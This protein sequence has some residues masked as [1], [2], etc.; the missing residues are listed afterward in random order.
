MKL[1]EF[2]S[3]S[4]KERKD[5]MAEKMWELAYY[6]FDLVE[7]SDS[8]LEERERY[9]RLISVGINAKIEDI[10]ALYEVSLK[11]DPRPEEG[12]K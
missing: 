8:G 6:V 12:Y 1:C 5:H 10:M 7:S 11:C 3:S 4:A 2:L 9:R